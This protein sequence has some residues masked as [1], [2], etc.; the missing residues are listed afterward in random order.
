[1]KCAVKDC[2]NYVHE[3]K[4]VGLLCSPC[5][6]FIA[7]DGGLYSQAHRNSRDMIDAAIAAER[8]AIARMFDGAVW[9][10]D[11]REIAAAIRARRARGEK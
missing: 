9:G 6:T 8:E 1:M 3:G 4:F 2:K 7:G 10:Y 5:H 11:Y